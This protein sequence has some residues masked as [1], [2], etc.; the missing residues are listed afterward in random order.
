MQTDRGKRRLGGKRWSI[1]DGYGHRKWVSRSGVVGDLGE[2][3]AEKRRKRRKAHHKKGAAPDKRTGRHKASGPF[4]GRQV[5]YDARDAR[6]GQRRSTEVVPYKARPV[7]LRQQQEAGVS[8]MAPLARKRKRNRAVVSYEERAV[9]PKRQKPAEEEKIDTSVPV[10]GQQIYASDP[11]TQRAI[12]MSEVHRPLRGGPV[13]PYE[14]A[15]AEPVQAEAVG[16]PPA[17]SRCKRK[18]PTRKRR[19]S[20]S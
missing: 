15:A 18:Q 8:G 1:T 9:V 6:S 12:K 20:F 5:A 11:D 2:D 13:V 4:A 17:E 7:A 10:G 19:H 3:E 14:A 16:L